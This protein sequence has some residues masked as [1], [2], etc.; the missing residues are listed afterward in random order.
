M[1]I[2]AVDADPIQA[3]RDLCDRHV[4]K[5]TLET[6]QILCSAFDESPYKKTHFNHPCCKWAR[7]SKSNYQWLIAHGLGL[8]AEYSLR[9][10]KTHKS[11]Q[12][13]QWCMANMH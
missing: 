1:N 6:A 8:S 12:V 2:F 9:Y 5:M 4:V 11:E 7:T 10:G 13:I 3:A